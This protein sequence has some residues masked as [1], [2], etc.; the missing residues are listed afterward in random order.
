MFKPK[1]IKNRWRPAAISALGT[2]R[3]RRAALLCGKLPEDL[4]IPVKLI[5]EPVDNLPKPRKY[6]LQRPIKA[7]HVKKLLENMPEQLQKFKM[8]K[9]ESKVLRKGKHPF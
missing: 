5:K 1:F 6:E 7:M 3:L 8:S 2:A 9:K 4:G